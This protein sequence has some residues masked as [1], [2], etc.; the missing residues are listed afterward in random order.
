MKVVFANEVGRLCHALNI[1]S[2]L[3]MEIFCKDTHQNISPL[4]FKPGYAFGGSCLPKDLRA[5]L[6]QAKTLDVPMELF[7]A[8]LD[9][10]RTQIDLGVQMVERLGNKNVGLL[11]LSFKVGTDDLRESPLVT[12][13]E[14]LL[15]RG[16]EL[17][18]FDEDVCMAKLLGTNREYIQQRLPH[19]GALLESSLERVVEQSE[20]IV[21]GNSNPTFR[22]VLNGLSA[23][24]EIVDLVRI[25]PEGLPVDSSYH[26]IGW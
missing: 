7:R 1:D 18:I 15:G 5:V 20:T 12:L 14:T 26:G 17:K 10:N 9:S 25:V 21:I 23:N 8:T 13:A 4:Y 22:K 6:Y 19:I 11:G 16:Y 24:K 3:L 2:H